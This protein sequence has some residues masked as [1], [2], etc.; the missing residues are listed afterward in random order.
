MHACAPPSDDDN[1]G[2]GIFVPA[3]E[4]AHSPGLVLG[5]QSLKQPASNTSC[6]GSQACAQHQCLP[7]LHQG[8]GLCRL[9]ARWPVQV[10]VNMDLGSRIYGQVRVNKV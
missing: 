6:S 10:D 7:R 4:A 8:G 9:P 2:E 1:D 3:T 5:Q